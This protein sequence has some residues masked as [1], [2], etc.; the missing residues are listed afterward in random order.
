MNHRH[1]HGFSLMEALI[2]VTILGILA[3]TATVGYSRYAER[4]HRSEAKSVMLDLSQ[5][6]ERYYTDENTYDG[7]SAPAPLR[8]VPTEGGRAQTYSIRIAT[9]DQ[10]FEII[11]SPTGAQVHDKCGELSTD[12]AGRHASEGGADCW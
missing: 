9:D 2:T 11:A 10:S 7:F 4:A 1:Q 5:R 3:A 8:Q 6:L 12:H